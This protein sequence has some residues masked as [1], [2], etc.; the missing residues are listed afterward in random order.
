M[1]QAKQ[2]PDNDDD[3]ACAEEKQSSIPSNMDLVSDFLSNAEIVSILPSFFADFVKIKLL[4][5]VTYKTEDI[6][7]ML[8]AH[9]KDNK[10]EA[11]TSHALYQKYAALAV[12]FVAAKIASKQSLYAHFKWQTIADWIKQLLNMFVQVLDKGVSFK[13]VVIDIEFPSQ[14]DSGETIHFGV[15]CDLCAMYPI[16]GDRYKCTVRSD[17]DCCSKCEAT[18]KCDYPLIKYKK[19]SRQHKNASFN[20]LQEM[21]G[22]LSMDN[23]SEKKED[24]VCGGVVDCICG[25][26][27]EYVRARDAYKRCN[28]VYCDSCNA[29]FFNEMVYH[30][31]RGY[32]KMHHANGYDLCPKCAVTAQP[33]VED[34]EEQLNDD[35]GNDDVIVPVPMPMPVVVVDDEEEDEFEYAVQLAQIKDIMAFGAEQDDALIKGMLVE[36]KGDI[37][38]VVPLL[39]Q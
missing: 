21:F 36:H 29:Q 14:T 15:E 34:D 11:I 28:T 1:Q 16:I 22:K 24:A 26:K 17:W 25:A 19:A 8:M 3:E 13:D 30:C 32:D 37:T 7:K 2:T 27:M 5:G 38:K 12:P 4:N 9:I 31:P 23:V 33:K 10:Y 6:A 18:R 35:E 39:L 20:G